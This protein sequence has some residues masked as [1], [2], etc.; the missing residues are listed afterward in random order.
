M[1][2]KKV[3]DVD[4]L[5]FN[6]KWIDLLR[7]VGFKEESFVKILS[8]IEVHSSY[9]LLYPVYI[10]DKKIETTLPY[11]LK[12]LYEIDKSNLLD[13]VIFMSQPEYYGD[14]YKCSVIT[15]CS[16]YKFENDGILPT[17]DFIND[18]ITVDCFDNLS[19][20]L[21]D[22][23]I[24]IYILFSNIETVDGILHIYNRFGTIINI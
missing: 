8:Y 22:R 18:Q 11:A 2:N 10:D 6:E 9:E 19:R 7:A 15:Y 4:T 5:K 23:K 17:E 13:E 21:K 3:V 16:K 1:K 12:V 20:L 14:N 24:G